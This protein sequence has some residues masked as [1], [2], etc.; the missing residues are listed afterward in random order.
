MI[1]LRIYDRSMIEASPK[2]KEYAE[3]LGLYDRA[4]TSLLCVTPIGSRKLEWITDPLLE[5]D[6][7]GPIP[8]LEGGDEVG[9][10]MAMMLMLGKPLAKSLQ[11]KDASYLMVALHSEVPLGIREERLDMPKRLEA[12]LYEFKDLTGAQLQLLA[13]H[14]VDITRIGAVFLFDAHQNRMV[15]DESGAIQP[16]LLGGSLGP[17]DA[18]QIVGSMVT[19]LAGE[20]VIRRIEI[21]KKRV[22]L[23]AVA[24]E[25]TNL[26]VMPIPIYVDDKDEDE[27]EASATEGLLL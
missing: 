15:L 25:R 9:I 16:F 2:V 27:D 3:S 12:R 10:L 19:G 6:G 23:V 11:I 13:E 18:A 24:Y 1:D 14:D 4:H 17:W 20:G 26:K 22:Y 7:L 21:S 5:E 8:V